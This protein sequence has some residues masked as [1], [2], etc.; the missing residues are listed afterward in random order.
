M[1]EGEFEYIKFRNPA[2]GHYQEEIPLEVF[3][4]HWID[5]KVK[6][7]SLSSGRNKYWLVIECTTPDGRLLTHE[8]STVLL[9]IGHTATAAWP[10][11]CT[12]EGDYS[13]N[14]FLYGGTRSYLTDS[15]SEL[16]ARAIYRPPK[17][18]CLWWPWE[19]PPLPRDRSS[20]WP[21]YEP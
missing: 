10:F 19:G 13:V 21:W 8:I 18:F 1:A 9:W 14:I 12:V 7:K 15:W 5:I 20:P 6:F 11:C 16:V 4:G 17:E 3:T 2:T